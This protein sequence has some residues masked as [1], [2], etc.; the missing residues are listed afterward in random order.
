MQ[1]LEFKRDSQ[2]N[3]KWHTTLIRCSHHFSL[4]SL[5]LP[6][7]RIPNPKE[8]YKSGTNPLFQPQARRKE[9]KKGRQEKTF[10][11]WSHLAMFKFPVFCTS[12]LIS[13]L[14]FLFPQSKSRRLGWLMGKWRQGEQLAFSGQSQLLAWRG[15]SG[16]HA[17]IPTR[18]WAPIMRSWQTP[19]LWLH[20]LMK[21]YFNMQPPGSTLTR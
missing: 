11:W 13:P 2:F 15:G 3:S 17:Q 21:A 20:S 7:P 6:F 14:L 9:W 18:P 16:K 10:D 8:G 12:P 5:S 19:W 4:Q 1:Q